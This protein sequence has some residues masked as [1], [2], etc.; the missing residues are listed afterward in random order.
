M[1]GVRERFPFSEN[2]VCYTGK[3]T[4]VERGIQYMRELAVRDLVYYDTDDE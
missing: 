4:N 2:I 3:W 1:S